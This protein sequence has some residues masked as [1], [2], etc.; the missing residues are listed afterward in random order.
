F[1]KGDRKALWC[2]RRRIPLPQKSPISIE[3]HTSKTG[4][5]SVAIYPTLVFSYI[6]LQCTLHQSS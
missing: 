5:T 6:H 4:K 2:A 3:Q 1:P